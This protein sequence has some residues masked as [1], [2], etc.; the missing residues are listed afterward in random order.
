MQRV[1][2]I[3]YHSENV[4][5]SLLVLE[6]KRAFSYNYLP[7]ETEE[8]EVQKVYTSFL[9]L[10]LYIIILYITEGKNYYWASQN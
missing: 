2:C 3:F 7:A 9:P 5:L 1:Q 8:E 10:Y 4:K 6:N